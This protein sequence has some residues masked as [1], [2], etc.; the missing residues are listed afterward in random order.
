MT[1]PIPDKEKYDKIQ[2]LADE[3]YYSSDACEPDKI[4]ELARLASPYLYTD[5]D[6]AMMLRYLERY[7]SLMRP[8]SSR[9]LTMRLAPNSSWVD[10]ASHCGSTVSAVSCDHG[11]QHPRDCARARGKEK[12]LTWFQRLSARHTPN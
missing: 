8:G 12:P 9:F 11:C 5:F 2:Q 4:Y 1:I 3:I 6:R 7:R 10:G